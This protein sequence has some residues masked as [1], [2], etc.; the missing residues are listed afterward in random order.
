VNGHYEAQIRGLRLP[1][2][3]L[4]QTCA[5]MPGDGAATATL[6]QR[7]RPQRLSVG[8][9]VWCGLGGRWLF[10]SAQCLFLATSGYWFGMTRPAYL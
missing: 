2:Q 8:L 6:K 7:L 4:G 9:R 10:P 5:G 1:L 3:P